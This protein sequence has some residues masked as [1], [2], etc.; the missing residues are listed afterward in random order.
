MA[1]AVV[2]V[3]LVVGSVIFHF[4]S[5]WWFTPIASNWGTMDDTVILTFWVTG[6]VFVVVNLFLAWTVIRYR[7]KKGQKADY[8]PENKKLEWWLTGITAV[9]VAAMLAP[10]LVVWGK[11]VIVPKEA[12]VV[13]AVGQQW[14]WSFRLPG[15]NGELGY[16]DASL[17]TPDNPFGVDP[18]DPNG[19]DDILIAS[20]ELHLPVGKPVKVLL[21]SNDVLHNFTVTQ[22]RVKMDLVPG[23]ITYLWMTPTLIGEYELLCEELCGLAHFAMRGRVVVDTQ[24]AYDAWLAEQPTF[25]DTQRLAAADPAAGAAQYVVCMACHGPAGEGNQAL[26][27]PRI[28]GQ[29]AWYL[30][31]QL[32]NFRAGVR[33]TH[34]QDTFG[35][36]MRAFAAMLPDD[37][38]IRNIAAHIESLPGAVAQPTVSGDLKRGKTLYGNCVACHGANGG[39][40]WALNAPRLAEMSDWYLARQLHNFRAEIRGAHRQDYYGRQMSFMANVLADERAIDDLISYVN[41]L[42]PEDNHV[43]ASGRGF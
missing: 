10:G 4:M 19:Q 33:G 21:R 3:L 20:P 11:F 32:H 17:I 39:G 41:T 34:E 27:A 8:E 7:H 29:S 2:L 22:F 1:I 24:E 15:E 30:V 36:Q 31:R 37:T 40:I 38:A 12:T 28:A 9:G 16:T 35:A 26:N 42:K 18:E 13:E 23:M 5:P 43:L 25:G 6:I 14:H